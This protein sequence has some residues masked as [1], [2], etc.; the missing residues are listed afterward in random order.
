MKITRRSFTLGS[1]AVLAALG[2]AKWL[3]PQFRNKPIPGEIVGAAAQRG[4]KL[5]TG[6]FP[7]PTVFI[8]KEV[9]IVGGG[10]S[11]L[12]AAYQLAKAGRADF[13]LLELEAYTG[14]NS[15]SGSNTVSAYPW[16]AHY[17][18]LVTDESTE[19]K[20]LFEDLGVITGYDAQGLP[21][22]NEYYICADPHERLFIYG[23][24]QDGLVPAIAF[25]DQDASQYKRF[26]DLMH[27]YRHLIGNDGHKVFAIPVDAS[28][29]DPQWLV[30]DHFTMEAWMDSQG[31]TSNSLRWYINYCCRD[32]FG[33]TLKETSA[34]AGIH[35]FAARSGRAANTDSQNVITWPEG[36]GW[37]AQKL[38][39]PIHP[40]IVTQALVFK[41]KERQ[42]KI[43]VDYWDA[44]NNQTVR[45]E[46]RAVVLATP[47][48]VAMRLLESDR[49]TL[50]ADNFSYSPWV[51]ANITLG[52]LPSGKGAPLSWDNVVYNSKLLGYVVATHQITQMHPVKTVITYYWPLSHLPPA[53]ARKEALER[54]YPEW[55]Q[56]ILQEL[57]SVHP[58][59]NGHIERMDLCIWGH[60]MI[61]PV[62]GF[63][64]GEARKQALVQQPPIFFSHSDM[65]GI[66]LFEEAY[67]H[68]VKAAKG[69]LA[70]LQQ[71]PHVS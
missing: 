9:V 14:G 33:S 13:T 44:A 27:R 12:G 53:E 41:V 47:R 42:G 20:K 28:S 10:I 37:L 69:V 45:I 21:I 22:Y 58:E 4:H 24:W 16:G 61:R 70:Y 62:Q 8:Q 43:T 5:R 40:H 2:T 64:W 38:A 26:F 48:F 50:S 11:G 59:L 31:F 32:D 18:P 49:F 46:A 29:Q 39:Q 34:W 36:N 17:V 1:L 68:G 65:S 66:S 25:A 55:Q 6:E 30:L 71:E 57:L 7:S 51:V 23:Q 19:V 35:Y 63:I 54:A 52:K 3:A 67:T 60:A 56:I 15:S